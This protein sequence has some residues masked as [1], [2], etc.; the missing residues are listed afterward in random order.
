MHQ[1]HNLEPSTVDY[2]AE[3]LSSILPGLESLSLN[4]GKLEKK[5]QFLK[6][7]HLGAPD[8]DA[9]R[10]TT[11]TSL[12]LI[13]TVIPE[14]AVTGLTNF[15]ASLSNLAIL[16][17]HDCELSEQDLA[18]VITAAPSATIRVLDLAHCSV[19]SSSGRAMGGL[20][21]NSATVRE[22]RLVDLH[23]ERSMITLSF[24]QLFLDSLA[25]NRSLET[26]H[27]AQVP[28]GHNII[29]QIGT[30][31]ASH[32]TLRRLVMDGCFHWSGYYGS[33]ALQYM[34]E[35]LALR[36]AQGHALE[37]IHFLDCLWLPTTIPDLCS[38]FTSPIPGLKILRLSLKSSNTHLETVT[39]L[40]TA[41]PLA[42]YTLA[43]FALTRSSLT[44]DM[45]TLLFESISDG[46]LVHR[47][48]RA[49]PSPSPDNLRDRAFPTFRLDLS[50][51]PLLSDITTQCL[52]SA[53][54]DFTALPHPPDIADIPARDRV[55]RFIVD[56]SGATLSDAARKGVR[57]LNG[58]NGMAD[59]GLLVVA[60][61][62]DGVGKSGGVGWK[63]RSDGF[64]EM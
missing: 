52:I 58:R 57:D 54:D 14:T 32:P 44:H 23:E 24:W 33:F 37:E 63:G 59:V 51:N 27:I 29:I 3:Y 1:L 41:L 30:A 53:W 11:I 38:F 12:R 47:I 31:L 49:P 45:L 2:A 8:L 55:A 4:F 64:D 18:H 34:W 7:I 40:L 6:L 62:D 15:I 39:Q 35:K 43:E 26:L 20:L 36:Q 17:L 56:L 46:R 19:G 21:R 25:F 60:G 48:L 42:T 28:L 10:Y 16:R 50:G 22:L 61:A 5:E 9:S 13:S